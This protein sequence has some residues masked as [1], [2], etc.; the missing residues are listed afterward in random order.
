M[1]FSR[2]VAVARA[3]TVPS[4]GAALRTG[5]SACVHTV[6]AAMHVHRD[7]HHAGSVNFRF[8]TERDSHTRVIGFWMLPEWT[9]E[10]LTFQ[11]VDLDHERTVYADLTDHVRAKAVGEV[12]R[13]WDYSDVLP[14]GALHAA[15]I[16]GKKLEIR[17]GE[18]LVACAPC[19]W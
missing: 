17:R 14:S 11:I 9:P 19:R 3:V 18:E 10:E 6:E 8:R 4:L 16:P 12:A 5:A 13:P 7:P 2:K 15:E 1:I